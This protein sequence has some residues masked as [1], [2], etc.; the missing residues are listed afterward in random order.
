MEA[1]IA[2]TKPLFNS[3][4]VYG[5]TKSELLKIKPANKPVSVV[6]GF[7]PRGMVFFFTAM[8]IFTFNIAL[9]LWLGELLGKAYYGFF[10]VAT[11]YAIICGILHF[12]MHDWMRNHFGN[13]IV[14][15]LLD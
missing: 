11:L 1:K 12:L 7:A 2:L 3:A 6:S 5:K 14:T 10:L 8:F 9:A 13:S 15:Q 4:E